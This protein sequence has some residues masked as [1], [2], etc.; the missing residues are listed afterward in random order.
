MKPTM[1]DTELCCL[2][3]LSE[4]FKYVTVRQ[5]EKM[6]LAKLLDRFPIAIK[7]SVE[8]PSAKIN[9]L[10]QAYISQLKLE[11]ISLT[12]NMVYITQVVILSSFLM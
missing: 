2:F 4:E 5:Y 6:E 7:E 10:L 11:G 1:R 12:S 8:E 9:V 3:S